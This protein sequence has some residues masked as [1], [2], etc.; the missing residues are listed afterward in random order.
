MRE[1]VI[2]D[3]LFLDLTVKDFLFFESLQG[4]VVLNPIVG[5]E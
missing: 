2:L 4:D 3:R 1:K 5:R